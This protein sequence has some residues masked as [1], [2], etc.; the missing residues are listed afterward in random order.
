MKF[1]ERPLVHELPLNLILKLQVNSLQSK[2]RY[3]CYSLL[4]LGIKTSMKNCSFN[5]KLVAELETCQNNMTHFFM[6]LSERP[7]VRTL[8]LKW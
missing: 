4:Q 1:F 3:L 8:H 6:R 5:D 2:D 7:L